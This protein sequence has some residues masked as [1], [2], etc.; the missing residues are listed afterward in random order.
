MHAILYIQQLV[1]F[2]IFEREER[3][4][5]IA[6]IISHVTFQMKAIC[7]ANI[8]FKRKNL[9][10]AIANYRSAYRGKARVTVYR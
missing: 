8:L 9:V 3:Y 7:F 10:V 6:L 5:S 4:H 2:L 1:L